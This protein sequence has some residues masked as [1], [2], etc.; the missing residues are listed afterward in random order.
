MYSPFTL[1]AKYARYYFTA[2]NGKG[3]GIHSPFVFEFVQKILNDRTRYPEYLR[4]E[5]LRRDLVKDHGS[6]EVL[7][8][9]AG[10]TVTSGSSR[11]VSQIA[12]HA[13]KPRKFGQL[14]FRMARFYQ[15]SGIFELGTSLGIS[16]AYLALGNS[17]AVTIS[18]EGSPL[19]AEKARLNLKQLRLTSAKIITGNFETQ[20]GVVLPG[21]ESPGMVFIDG[22]H[23]KLPTIDYFHQVLPYM[24]TGSILIFDDIHWSREMEEAWE[25]IKCHPDV[26]LTV[27]LFF[28]GIIFFRSEFLVKQHFAIRF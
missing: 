21:L 23:R 15:P 16:T 18:I 5:E 12:R 10:S 9:G 14:L 26:K 13:A 8:L 6:I 25:V 22:N 4:V 20:L 7:D 2:A 1:A 28:V 17:A 24:Q 19:I 27:D 11:T 3:H